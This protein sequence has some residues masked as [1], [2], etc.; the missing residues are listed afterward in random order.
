MVNGLHLFSVFAVLLVLKALFTQ[1]LIHPFVHTITQII[2]HQWQSHDTADLIHLEPLSVQC[3]S[4]GHFNI[5]QEEPEIEPL[6]LQLVASCS[7]SWT[8]AAH[9]VYTY[10]FKRTVSKLEFISC[11]NIESVTS[12]AGNNHLLICTRSTHSLLMFLKS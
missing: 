6:T 11:T 9:H 10:L 7:I 12:S 2:T 5:R 1:L 3:L 8:T 4:K